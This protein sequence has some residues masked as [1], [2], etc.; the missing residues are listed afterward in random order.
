MSPDMATVLR[1]DGRIAGAL[2]LV[3]VL[4][5]MFCLAYVPQR[6]GGSYVDAVS[7]QGL[8]RAGIAAF[9]ATAQVAS[10]SLNWSLKSAGDAKSRPGMNDVSNQPLRRS[11]TPFDSGSRGGS[12]TSLVARVPMNAGTP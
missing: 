11:T 3:V 2:Y 8:F 10:Q 6:A 1:R 7:H 4:T 12:N 9:L 5:G